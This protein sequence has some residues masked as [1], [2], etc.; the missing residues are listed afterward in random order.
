MSVA[1]K[2]GVETPVRSA[3][4]AELAKGDEFFVERILTLALILLVAFWLRAQAPGYSTAYMDESV[5]VVYGR[6]F[7][8]RHFEAPLDS[9]LRWSFGWYLWPMISATADRVGGIIAVREL[10]AALGTLAVAAAYGLSRRLYGSAVAL[11]S[12]AVIALAAPAVMASRIATRDAG[13]IVFLALGLW[14]YAKAWQENRAKDWLVAA[15]LLFS[16]FLCKYIVAIY[17]PALVIIALWRGWRPVAL[18]CAPMTAAAAFYLLHY[19]GDL[20][21]LLLYGKGYGSLK[22]SG[23]LLWEVYVGRR[24][25]LWVIG[26]LALVALLLTERRRATL[27]MWLGAA[28]AIAFQWWTR[29]DFDFWKHATYFLIFLAPPAVHTLIVLAR[30]V[31]RH[32]QEQTVAALLSVLALLSLTAWTGK[33]SQFNQLVFWPNVEPILAYFEGRL[34]N[35]ARVLVDD[36]VFRYYYHPMLRQWQIAD[37]FYFRYREQSGANAYTQ[38]VEDGAFDYI[39]LDGG[40]GEEAQAMHAAIRD[41]LQRYTLKL[42]MPDPVLGHPIEIYERTEPATSTTANASESLRLTWPR[43]KEPVELGTTITGKATGAENGSYVRVEVLSDRWYPVARVPVEADGGFMTKPVIFGGQ[44]AQA[45]NHAVRARLYSPA[46]R[47]VSVA[48]VFNI[49]RKGAE[50]KY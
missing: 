42:A 49:P 21:Y 9:P 36:S 5:Y 8:S 41:H 32:Y 23:Q 47:P 2:P 11:G 40:M 31:G 13:S 37:P 43:S 14:A 44:G 33:S 28:T 46:N 3:P 7:L 12:A 50:C 48:T 1:T 27:L 45:C 29:A 4:P 34:P 10:A 38:A 17:F 24:I 20:K 26:A 6:M 25:E 30:K 16:A 18:F 39:A 15:A 19:W 35:N 22:A